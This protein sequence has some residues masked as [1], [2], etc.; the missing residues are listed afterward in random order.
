MKCGVLDR[1]V[2]WAQHKSQIELS[3]KCSSSK[4][5]KLKGIP[6]LDDANDAGTKNSRDCTLILTEGDSARAL[7]VAGLGVIGR[8]KYGVFP[9]RGMSMLSHLTV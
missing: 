9:L 5:S 7:A 3:K 2:D 4:R 1:I 6:K 8:D